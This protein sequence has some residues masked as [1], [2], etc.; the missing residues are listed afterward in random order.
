MERTGWNRLAPLVLGAA[1]LALATPLPAQALGTPTTLE[2][3]EVVVD[4]SGGSLT[5][6]PA[7]GAITAAVGVYPTSAL[8]SASSA[9][10]AYD[11]GGR[12]AKVYFD[13]A[14]TISLSGTASAFTAL[15]SAFTTEYVGNQFVF[16]GASNLTTTVLFHVG[17]TLLIPASQPAGDYNGQLTIYIKDNIGANTA[18]A[19]VPVHIRIRLPL[20]ISKTQDLDMGVVIPGT[21]GGNVTLDPATGSQGLTGGVLYASSSGLPAQFSVTGAPNN[22]FTIAFGSSTITLTGPSGTM[23]LALNGSPSGSATLS[24]AGT[25]ALNVGGTLSVA[26]NQAEGTYAGTLTVTVAYP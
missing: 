18:Y 26:A 5:L 1:L 12:T 4:P 16:P 17:G 11:K 13:S 2:F 14:A 25:A 9:V 8:A 6:D 20:S 21:T 10:T 15:T 24:A 23:S 3:G 19:Y 7:T 22:T